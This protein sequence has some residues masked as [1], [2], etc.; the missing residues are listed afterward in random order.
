M[1]GRQRLLEAMMARQGAAT[2]GEYPEGMGVGGLPAGGMTGGPLGSVPDGYPAGGMTGGPLGSVPDG[3]PEGMGVG[4][5]PAGGMTGGPFGQTGGAPGN[6]T[7]R[8]M[9]LLRQWQNSQP[10]PPV[11]DAY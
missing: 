4:G 6:M 11:P 1:D 9:E 5:L 8:E 7:E 2:G 3:Y 10:A